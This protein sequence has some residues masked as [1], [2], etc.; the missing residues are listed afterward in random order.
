MKIS[1]NITVL[2]ARGC[3]DRMHNFEKIAFA[4]DARAL[5]LYNYDKLSR[6]FSC[7]LLIRNHI[8]FLV[9]FGINKYLLI[10]SKTTK[11]TRPTGSCNF[12][13]L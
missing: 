3:F 9:Q 2:I 5:L 8:I 1:L 4:L 6:I 11:C 12:V 10:F 13:S 7:I